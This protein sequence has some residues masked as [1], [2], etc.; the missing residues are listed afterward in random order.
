MRGAAA[1]R[2][3]L[4]RAAHGAAAP[5]LADAQLLGMVLRASAWRAD[6]AGALAKTFD[7]KDARTADT[8]T[9]RGAGA[10]GARG[11]GRGARGGSD[12][13]ALPT[14]PC[15]ARALPP[16]QLLTSSCAQAPFR[17]GARRPRR[18]P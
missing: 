17:C 1:L 10:G 5:P 13:H 15:A 18:S 8:F 4:A 9:A 7:F 11:A 2:P 12:T 16:L 14:L 6:G 3:L